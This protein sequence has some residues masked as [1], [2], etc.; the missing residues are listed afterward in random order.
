LPELAASLVSAMKGHADIAIGAVVGS[1]IF[2]LLIV[3]AIPGFFEDVAVSTS[4][5]LRDLGTV[6]LSTTLLTFFIWTSWRRDTG[7]ASLGPAAGCAFLAIYVLYY[8]WL[9]LGTKAL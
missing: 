1:N 7:T 3:L 5:L 4:D 6:A 9:T 8:V 2:N